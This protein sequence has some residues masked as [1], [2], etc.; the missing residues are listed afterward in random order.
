LVG[1]A[2]PSPHHPSPHRARAPPR[3]GAP[4]PTA[5]F[6]GAAATSRTASL[7][8]ISGRCVREDQPHPLPCAFIDP[9][10]AHLAHVP[11]QPLP[12]Q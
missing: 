8:S 10:L 12:A 11:Q 4:C 9:E 5:S 7:S 2:H 6:R 3:N 1:S